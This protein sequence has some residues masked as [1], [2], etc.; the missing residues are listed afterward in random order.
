MGVDLGDLQREAADH[1]VL[2]LILGHLLG[3]GDPA[4]VVPVAGGAAL[5]LDVKGSSDA[6]GGDEGRGD[7]VALRKVIVDEPG[8]AD[9]VLRLVQRGEAQGKGTRQ[10]NHI[11]A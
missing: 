10:E 2:V 8:G 7:R 3:D 6:A 5:L 11:L 4:V 1:D 9:V